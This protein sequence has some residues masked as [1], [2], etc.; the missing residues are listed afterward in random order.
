MIKNIYKKLTSLHWEIGILDNTYSDIINN[1]GLNFKLVKHDYPNSWFA[2]PFILDVKDGYIDVLVE[3]VIAPDPKGHI[4]KLRIDKN[5]F[6]VID[7]KIVFENEGHLSF[8]VIFRDEDRVYVYPENS[9]TGSLNLYEYD[10]SS[11]KLV[12]KT[13]IIEK[14]LTDAIITDLFD[15]KYMFATDTSDPNGKKISIYKWN[16]ST[17]TFDYDEAYQFN[18]NIARMGGDFFIV[19]G[20]IYRP[21]QESNSSYGHGISIQRVSKKNGLWEF[22]EIRRLTSPCK[23]LGIGFHT[24]NSYKGCVVVD[25]KGYRHSLLGPLLTYIRTLLS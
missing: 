14:P 15:H 21:A 19:D 10:T 22:D 7:K 6:K 20:I 3:E 4:S 23:N 18:E 16:E 5:T 8:P 9:E 2:D 25:V 13:K 1:C 17:N 24:L 12:F 11:E